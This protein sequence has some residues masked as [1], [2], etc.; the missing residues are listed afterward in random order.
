MVGVKAMFTDLKSKY[1]K[2]KKETN[3]YEFKPDSIAPTPSFLKLRTPGQSPRN[4]Q[5]NPK[6]SF[7]ITQFGTVLSVKKYSSTS[8][9]KRVEV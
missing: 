3:V 9:L 2:M 5:R 8:D 1:F 4:S 6:N 7:P